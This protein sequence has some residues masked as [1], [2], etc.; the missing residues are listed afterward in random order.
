MG[1][2]KQVKLGKI[3]PY[4]KNQKKHPAKHI[5]QVAKSIKEFGF[6]QPIVVDKQGVIIV[7]H[8]RYEAAKA[9][10]LPTVPCLEVD[11]TDEQAKAYR[12]ADNK[13]NESDWDMGLVIEELK[14]LSPEMLDLTGFDKDLIIEPDEKDDEVPEIPEEPKSKLGDLYELGEHRVLCGDSTQEEAVLRLCGDNKAQMCFTD[15][16]YNIDYQGGMNTHG[17][18]KR[19]GIQND[20]MG[21]DAFREFLSKALKPIVENTEGGIYVCMSSSELDSL[22]EAFESAGGHWQSFIIWVKNNFTL[23]RADYQNTFEPILYGWNN[24]VV[25]HYFSDRRDMA[26]VWEDLSKVKTEFDGKD[27]TISFQGFKVKINGKVEKG[28]VIRKKQRT[29]IWRCD[30]PNRSAEHP[31]MKPIALVQE[32]IENSSKQGQIVLDTF[33]GSGSTLIASEKT[34]RICYGMELDPKYIDVIVQRYVDYTGNENIIK[35]GETIQWPK[36]KEKTKETQ[37]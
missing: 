37:G 18:N 17:Q 7:G 24:K 1:T 33:L 25:N 22:K 35:N 5:E 26:N 13:L 29:D 6:N 36:T 23:S 32:A 34:G 9:L 15:P 11:L 12:L 8:G 19:D 2:I 16:P 31:T 20:K 27:T 30:K 10:K 28:E 4:E 14:G 3:F 21:K